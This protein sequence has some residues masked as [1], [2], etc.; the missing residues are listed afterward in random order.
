MTTFITPALRGLA[1]A[2]AVAFGGLAQ[3]ETL[4]IAS[5]G[6]ALHFYPFYVAEKAGL[7][8]EEGIELDWVD[9]GSGSKQI[10]AVAG[11]SAEMAVV[12]MQAAISARQNGADLVSIAA[13]FNAYPIQLVLSNAALEKSGIDPAMPIDEKVAKLK[14]LNIAVT[15]I[16]STT[17]VLLRSWF[18]A[19][20]MDP[21]TEITI[22]PLGN[23]GAMYAAF[24]QGQVDGFMLGAPFTQK[25]ELEGLG[26]TA[27]DPLD[28]GIP[29]LEDVPYT[30]IITNERTVAAKPEL[31]QKSLN[32]LARAMKL[33]KE[34]PEKVQGLIKEY[35][36]DTPDAAYQ[37][38]EPKFR[39]NAATTPVLTQAEYDNLLKWIAITSS[40]KLDVA[41]DAF[42]V[43]TFAD[44]A[45]GD[46]LK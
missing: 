22:Q 31:L 1:V 4:T 41:Y 7:F 44:K 36:P 12:G 6:V 23:P 45:A 29:E 19:R 46:I 8:A 40:D 2:A 30:A 15:G 21:D 5:P 13:L 14:G 35:F 3:A 39:A 18:K 10:A 17:D 20:G 28:G 16:G 32:A 42:V 38:F 37:A 27:I 11:G 34:D 25:A 33:T 9:V 24:E 43:P 26:K